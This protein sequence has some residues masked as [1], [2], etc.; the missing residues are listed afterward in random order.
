M[1]I[2]LNQTINQRKILTPQMQTYDNLGIKWHP[3]IMFFQRPNFKSRIVNTDE[4]GF[5]FN[6]VKGN[7]Y[8]PLSDLKKTKKEVSFIVG[9]S[10]VFGVGATN[11][12]NTISSII[13]KETSEKFLNFGCRAYVSSQELI[14]FN[15]ISPRFKKIKNVI[16]FSGL[17]DLYLSFL[18]NNASELGPFFFSSQ[19]SK[20][21]N[22]ELISKERKLL[23]Y[24]LSP[25]YKDNF[26][27]EKFSFKNLMKDIFSY[28]KKEPSSFDTRNDSFDV[29][30]T[31]SQLKKNLLIWKKLSE[32]YPFNLIF[33]LQPTLDWMSK[34]ASKEEKKII[35][36]GDKQEDKMRVRDIMSKDIY[37]DYSFALK[38]LCKSLDITFFDANLDLK[39]SFKQ[40]D[41][42]FVDR[43]GHMTDLGYA[44]VGKYIKNILENF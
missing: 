6:Q 42:I 23:K 10:T 44:N 35:E 36:Y 34:P 28:Q 13:S 3:Y 26:D 40:D 24:L 8:S 20:G 1:K 17:N 4:F 39:K 43:G 5:R 22:N 21:M 14:L 38:K 33:I 27:Y 19:F 12:S 31:I 15:Q 32:S 18:R 7:R 25:I 9:N 41:W 11:D 37:R 30:Y 2:N 16:I 29:L